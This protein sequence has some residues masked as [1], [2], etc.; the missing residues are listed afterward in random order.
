MIIRLY[1]MRT[2]MF[3]KIIKISVAN[4]TVLLEM[5]SVIHFCTIQMG[6]TELLVEQ[7][8]TVV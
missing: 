4:Y 2:I 3:L 5:V 7:V 1:F 6:E 8:G